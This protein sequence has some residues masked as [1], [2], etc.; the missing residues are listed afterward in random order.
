MKMN[1]I[2]N[3]KIPLTPNISNSL[4]NVMYILLLDIL[5]KYK[6]LYFLLYSSGFP[7]FRLT[8]TNYK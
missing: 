7:N 3:I 1:V 8:F 6:E 2:E 5:Y 4:S